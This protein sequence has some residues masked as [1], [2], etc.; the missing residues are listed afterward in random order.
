MTAEVISVLVLLAVFGLAL[1]RPV[2][3]GALA[4]V[5]AFVL[6]TVYFGSSV[7]EIAAGF[8]ASLMIT[9]IGVTFLFGLAKANGTVDLVVH[10]AVRAVGGRL[11]LVPW[12]F[13]VL[14]ALI[15]AAGAVTA[16]TNAILVPIGIALAARHRINPLLV[17]LSIINGTNAGGFSPISVYYTIV[18]GG[19]DQ[20]GVQVSPLP[21]FAATFLF[22]L[23]LNAAAV[24]VLGGWRHKV[25]VPVAAGVGS[26]GTGSE[27]PEPEE[28]RH[29]GMEQQVTV[30]AFVLV[31]AGVLGLGL[32]IGFT[33]LTAGVV[34]ALLFPHGSAAAAGSIAWPVVLLIG[35]IITYISLLQ[36]QGV[37][38]TLAGAVG[39]IGQPLLAAFLLLL[40]AGL[41]SAFASTNAMFGVVVPLAAPFLATGS[42]PLLGFVIALCIAASAV[43]SSPFSTG[44]ALIV[45]SS[46][47]EHRTKVFRGLMAWGMSMIAVAPVA[48]WVVFVLVPSL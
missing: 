14:A 27:L 3:M 31:I 36:A 18:A 35:G 25:Q 44:G 16:A 10:G 37:V 48:A 2:N 20:A 6:G 47:E 23:A 17:G 26:G 22:N 29:W 7:P 33:A 32:D 28:E 8:P 19:L 24:T 40:I 39:G 43:D 41:V 45:A 13:F 11:V 4:L 34:L 12:V 1:W 42:L 21:V 38:A 30:L 5:A 15:T 9:L 46:E